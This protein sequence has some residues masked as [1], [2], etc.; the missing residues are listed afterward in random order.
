MRPGLRLGDLDLRQGSFHSSGRLIMGTDSFFGCDSI[1][2]LENRKGYSDSFGLL[3]VTSTF[4]GKN[5]GYDHRTEVLNHSDV[6]IP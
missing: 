5:A 3:L 6:H 4:T 2:P 1:G